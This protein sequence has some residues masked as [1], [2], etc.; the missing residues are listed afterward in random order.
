MAFSKRRCGASQLLSLQRFDSTGRIWFAVFGVA[1]EVRTQWQ[2]PGVAKGNDVEAEGGAGHVRASGWALSKLAERL[3]TQA[4][5]ATFRQA[6]R[7]L[8]DSGR[9]NRDDFRHPDEGTLSKPFVRR[10]KYDFRH[11]L[12]TVSTVS[13]KL[14]TVSPE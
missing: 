11:R 5:R 4:G 9:L 3:G 1:P 7:E 10:W 12:P 6:I 14:S 13:R 8:R 2:R